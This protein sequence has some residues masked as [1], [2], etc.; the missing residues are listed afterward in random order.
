M[1]TSK[2]RR[3]CIAAGLAALLAAPA[4]AQTAYPSQ[5]LK[6]IVPYPAGGATD[7]LARTIGQKL[8]EAWNQPA[9]VENRPGAG[10]TIGNSFV[11]KAPADGHT[12]LIAITA[13]IQ[14]PSLMEK[15]PY[16][17]LKDFAPVTMIARSPSM[18]A[19]PLDS[20][21][22]DL[23]SFI[24]MVKASPGKHNFGSY[25]AGTSSHIQ[26][27]LLNM[28][29]GI[30]LVHVPFQGAA[31]LVTNLVG[32]QLASAFIDSASARP[33]LKSMRPLAVTGTQRMPGLPDVPTFAELGYHS[34]DPYG[35]FGV[36]VPAA[37]P[38][39]V[40]QKL[41][42]EI[43]RILRLPE[44]TAKIEALGLQVGGGKPEEFQKMV[45]GD[46]AIYAKIIKDAN[47]RLAP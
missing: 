20:P 22:K 28:Q 30:D 26:G 11:A 31:P 39:P 10:G 34:F 7:T 4:L 46:A 38:A 12:M 41:S 5:Q 45:R 17:P 18:L 36:F 6:L 25:G 14:Q 3:L 21:A 27:A 33:H 2:M 32:G 44:V 40:V 19:V 9:V 47:I 35:W 37:T 1:K 42:D 15:L 23:K 16:D 43:D 13:L 8:Q 24:A 29:A